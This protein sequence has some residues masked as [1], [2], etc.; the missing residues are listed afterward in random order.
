MRRSFCLILVCAFATSLL[1]ENEKYAVTKPPKE[2]QLTGFYK[3]HVSAS[4]YPVISSGNV[5]DYALKEAAFLIDKMLANRKDVRA[6]MIANGSRMIVMGY[7]EYTTDIPEHSRL[8]PKEYWDRRA[9]GLGGSKHDPVC[10]S[11]EENL[12]AYPGDPYDQENILIHEFAHNIHLVGLC[13]VDPTL[14]ID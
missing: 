9:R 10:S 7:Q 11:A 3:K 12:L 5:D 4:G 2:L 13:T 6:A 14:M 1:A 8:K